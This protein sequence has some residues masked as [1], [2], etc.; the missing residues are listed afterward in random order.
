MKRL[1]MWNISGPK[2]VGNTDGHLCRMSGTNL[3]KLNKRMLQLREFI[4][5][6]FSRRPRSFHEVA[7]FKATEI[8]QLQLYTAKIVFK[9]LMATDKHYEHLVT[10]SSVC[11]LLVDE[12]TARPYYELN[13]KL[14]KVF[15]EG[16]QEL[17]GNSFVV[18]NVHTQLH[19]PEVAKVH[20]SVDNVSAY[21][22][23][24]KLGELKK[25]IRSSH[26]PIL[27]MIKGIQRK[28]AA[29]DGVQ[30]VPEMAEIYT[31]S[32]NNI[33]IS[34]RGQCYQ[35]IGFKHDRVRCIEYFETCSFYRKPFDSRQIGCYC[36]RSDKY[37]YTTVTSADIRHCRRGMRI[38]LGKLEGMNTPDNANVSVFMS[39]LHDPEDSFYC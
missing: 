30:P 16:C 6:C 35:V 1:L 25:I 23:E 28:Q 5:N 29:M 19:F 18:Y 24:S 20:G 27:S 9:G 3:V 12:R 17:Y 14:M 2:K 37:R 11:A 32:P 22:F 13:K 36:V 39:L 33:Y 34:K 26:R 31:K 10:Y 21:V 38:D 15:V 4:P 7:Y 8:R